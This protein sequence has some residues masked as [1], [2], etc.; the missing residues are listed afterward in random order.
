MAHPYVISVMKDIRLTSIIIQ[1]VGQASEDK[2]PSTPR[3]TP[4]HIDESIKT[5]II[6]LIGQTQDQDK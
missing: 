3:I 1:M 4:V 2:A 6:S 5:S